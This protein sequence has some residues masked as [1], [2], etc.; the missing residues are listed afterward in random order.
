MSQFTQSLPVY[1]FDCKFYGIPM[2]QN[3]AYFSGECLMIVESDKYDTSNYIVLHVE[4]SPAHSMK[5]IGAFWSLDNARLFALAYR[6]SKAP[7]LEMEPIGL[8]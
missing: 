8:N 1:E 2:D 3:P 4:Q 6:I 5:T 7:V